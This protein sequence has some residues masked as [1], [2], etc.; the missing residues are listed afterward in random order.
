MNLRAVLFDL[1]DTL[2]DD[3]LTY[4]RAAEAVANEVAAQRGVAAATL[5][6][7]YVAEADRFWQ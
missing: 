6:N 2:H 3:T 1:D 5:M 7:A 4:R